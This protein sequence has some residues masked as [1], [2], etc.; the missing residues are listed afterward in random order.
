[1][2][3]LQR[4][5]S[6]DLIDLFVDLWNSI[7]TMQ[8]NDN[9]DTIAW[10]SA[11]DGSYSVSSAYLACFQERPLKPNLASIWQ[12]RV[13]GKVRFFFWLILQNQTKFLYSSVFPLT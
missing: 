7:E 1:M 10:T 11:A 4:I 6:P 13:E 8:L 5:N 12:V 3:G 2:K 9:D